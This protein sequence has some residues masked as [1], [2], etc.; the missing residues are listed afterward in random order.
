M[1]VVLGPL[2]V[3]DICVSLYFWKFM[4]LLLDKF[5]LS[6]PLSGVLNTLAFVVSLGLAPPAYSFS[7]YNMR[8]PLPILVGVT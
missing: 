8:F 3:L 7:S 1:L 2:I 4:R 5:N 6:Y